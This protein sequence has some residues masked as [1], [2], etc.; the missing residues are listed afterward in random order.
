[1]THQARDIEPGEHISVEDEHRLVRATREKR[2]GM[3]DRS[4]GAERL[5]LRRDDDFDPEVVVLDEFAEHFGAIARPEHDPGD[6]G[7]TSASDLMDREGNPRNRK[8][9]LGSVDGQRTQAGSLASDE[10]HCFGHVDR[11]PYRARRS[12]HE[13]PRMV[14]DHPSHALPWRR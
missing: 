8:H 7:V 6:S 3:P 10:E 12:P 5:D 2:Q 14:A 1:M 13:P 11:V 9:R 4:T